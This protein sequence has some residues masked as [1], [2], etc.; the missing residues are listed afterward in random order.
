MLIV[1]FAGLYQRQ[2]WNT[3]FIHSV[4]PLPMMCYVLRLGNLEIDK[5]LAFGLICNIRDILFNVLLL[6][7]SRG[8]YDF[9]FTRKH[10]RWHHANDKWTV[11][12]SD[13]F[14]CQSSRW[15]YFLWLL[16]YYVR[17]TNPGFYLVICKKNNSLFSINVLNL[18]LSIF[19]WAFGA[20]AWYFSH[21]DLPVRALPVRALH[22]YDLGSEVITKGHLYGVGVA[23]FHKILTTLW[24]THILYLTNF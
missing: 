3:P 12:W 7:L 8:H 5:N 19:T 16:I 13:R 24:D 4:H 10:S 11:L 21:W 17:R 6:P 15:R 14:P 22:D 23:A 18:K 1:L 2:N 9:P 20:E